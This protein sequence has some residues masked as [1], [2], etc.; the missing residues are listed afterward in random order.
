[1][2]SSTPPGRR[3]LA[4]WVA[5]ALAL[6]VGLYALACL[7]LFTLQRA[8]LFPPAEKTATIAVESTIAPLTLRA[9][10]GVEAHALWLT[11]SA[12][13]P[14]LVWFHGNGEDLGGDLER[15]RVLQREGIASLVVEYRGYGLSKASGAASEAGL[16]A[17]A[18][19]ALDALPKLGVAASRIVLVGRSLGTGVATEMASR[20]RGSK[21]VLISP[22]TSIPDVAALEYPIFPVHLLARDRFETANKAPSITIP[23]LIIHGDRDELIPHSMGALLATRFPHARLLTL[24]GGHHDDLFDTHPETL[25]AI[26]AFAKE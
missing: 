4:R 10:D 5:F 2:A 7:A 21:L 22:Y 11:A 3:S 16:Y 19:A 25:E 14:V 26:A 13:A 9:G 6:V 15:A 1:M 20:G 23:T 18:Q 12:P 17:D 8:L 24:S